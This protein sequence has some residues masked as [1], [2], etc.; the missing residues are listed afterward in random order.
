[1][2]WP[3]LS[4]TASCAPAFAESDASAAVVGAPAESVWRSEP[5]S[6]STLN[7]VIPVSAATNKVSWTA[8]KDRT[9]ALIVN[10]DSGTGVSEPSLL[11]LNAVIRG[12]LESPTKRN[13]GT[14]APMGVGVGVG[15]GVGEMVGVGV[16]EGLPTNTRRGEITQPATSRNSKRI[17]P[18]IMPGMSDRQRRFRILKLMPCST[19]LLPRRICAVFTPM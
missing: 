9:G 8:D 3:V 2:N 1:M 17:E 15:V 12:A 14:V 4:K 6:F 5:V 18:I 11:I 7:A 16:G 19:G 10:G 13:C